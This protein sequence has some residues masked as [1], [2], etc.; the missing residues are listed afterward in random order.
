VVEL[1]EAPGT[2]DY[3]TGDRP[4][5]A[6]RPLRAVI[7]IEPSRGVLLP[8]LTAAKL[9]LHERFFSPAPLGL[10][11]PEPPTSPFLAAAGPSARS[12]GKVHGLFITP[13]A[14]IGHLS[15]KSDTPRTVDFG[16]IN[17]IS[18]GLGGWQY[19]L[20]APLRNLRS[21]RYDLR[22]HADPPTIHA[23]AAPEP[24]RH[25]SIAISIASIGLICVGSTFADRVTVE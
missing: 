6:G 11:S 19:W 22:I 8:P 1:V 5:A 3:R 17:L 10:R 15:Q 12:G 7:E 23:R 25:G 9:G 20:S 18:A 24:L 16:S 4:S 21:R 13:V 14:E 2:T